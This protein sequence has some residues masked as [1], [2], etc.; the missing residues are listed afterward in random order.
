[1][2]A[3]RDVQVLG[4]HHI[5]RRLHQV[6]ILQLVLDA[7][8]G[9][10]L[11]VHHEGA[12]IGRD[13]EA[14]DAAGD[15][16]AFGERKGELHFGLRFQS[17]ARPLVLAGKALEVVE[18]G[19]AQTLG[20]IAVGDVRFFQAAREN[21]FEERRDVL[22]L[23]PPFGQHLVH[24]VALFEEGEALLGARR[25]GLQTHQALREVLK[26]ALQE[27]LQ[28]GGRQ[29]GGPGAQVIEQV[30]GGDLRGAAR[31]VDGCAARD[32]PARNPP[33]AP[34]GLPGRWTGR[35]RSPRASNSG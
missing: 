34:A 29:T 33:P 19:V 24:D 28:R 10:V 6:L 11:V 16:Q 32:A 15:F 2:P 5:E 17:R 4:G 8:R 13:I 31:L 1:M 35:L 18:H 14:I 27:G 26:R 30:R 25:G 22:R 3:G 12:A 20:V 7:L 21:P 9:A 23:L